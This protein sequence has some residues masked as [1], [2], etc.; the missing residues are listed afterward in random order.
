MAKYY[1]KLNDGGSDE[2]CNGFVDIM[3]GP[4]KSSIFLP[5]IENVNRLTFP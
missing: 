5:S 3:G 1:T 4:L 2:L